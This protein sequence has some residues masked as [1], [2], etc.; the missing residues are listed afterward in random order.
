MSGENSAGRTRAPDSAYVQAVTRGLD[1]LQAV[2]TGVCP[3]CSTCAHEHD[4]AD[5]HD[6]PA[7]TLAAFEDAWRSG[8]LRG[9]GD[10]HFSWSPCDICGSSLGGD[11]EIWHAI[12]GA[13]GEKLAGRSIEHFDNAC[14]DCVIFLAN[15]DEPEGW[16]E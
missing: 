14:T 15:G 10:S 2:S 4:Y 13:P 6:D 1:G 3:G 12:A 7:R 11:R 5:D 8:K 9:D 16:D